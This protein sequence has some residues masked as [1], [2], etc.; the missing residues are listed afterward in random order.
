MDSP[1]PPRIFSSARRRQALLR[2]RQRQSSN[3][4]AARYL[5]EDAISDIEDR[6]DFTRTTPERSLVIGEPTGSLSRALQGHGEVIDMSTGMI[7]EERPLPHQELDLLVHLF[8]F[9]TINDLPGALLHSRAALRAGG[10]LIASFPGA[11][12]L[13]SLRSIM[14]AAD[15]ERPAPRIH[16][17]IDNSAAASLLQRAG[18]TRQVVDSHVITVRYSSLRTMV[19]DLRDQGLA[20]VLRRPGPPLDRAAMARAETAFRDLAD[21]QGKVTEKFEMLTLTAWKA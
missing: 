1:N 9:A 16:P 4:S 11:G 14:L 2:A 21:D 20:S 5:L 18:F 7:D 8:G 19:A 12:S 17:L 6:L 13:Q 15:G 10:M 3:L